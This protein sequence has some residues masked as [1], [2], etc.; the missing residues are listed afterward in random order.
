MMNLR[1]A[2]TANVHYIPGS[3]LVSMSKPERESEFLKNI[4]GKLDYT[5]DRDLSDDSDAREEHRARDSCVAVVTTEADL[6]RGE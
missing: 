1:E 4:G 5:W 2:G 6:T 3:I